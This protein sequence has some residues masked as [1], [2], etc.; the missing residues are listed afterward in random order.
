MSGGAHTLHETIRN[1]ISGTQKAIYLL[2]IQVPSA[3]HPHCIIGDA[4]RLPIKAHTFDTVVAGELVEHLRKPWL[5]FEECARILRSEGN[6]ILTTPN[7]TFYRNL[8][9]GA[10]TGGSHVMVMTF[11]QLD[12][13]LCSAGFEIVEVMF[14]PYTMEASPGVRKLFRYLFW[15]RRLIHYVLPKRFQEQIILLAKNRGNISN[16]HYKL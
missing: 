11:D 14:Q 8:L 1:K 10:N 15:L 13:L 4:H 5:F 3:A 16:Q 2:D 7:L 12:L 9:F 6:L